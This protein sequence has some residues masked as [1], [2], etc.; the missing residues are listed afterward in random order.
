M[1]MCVQWRKWAGFRQAPSNR[2]KSAGPGVVKSTSSFARDGHVA[3]TKKTIRGSRFSCQWFKK[4]NVPGNSDVAAAHRAALRGLGNTP[5]L[6]LERDGCDCGRAGDEGSSQNRCKN[7][8]ICSRMF[9]YVRLSG[10]TRRKAILA[11]AIQK[12]GNASF[13][14]RTFTCACYTII[15]GDYTCRY[16]A[17][18]SLDLG[19]PWLAHCR[20]HQ[21]GE[22]HGVAAATPYRYWV[23]SPFTAFYRLLS[24]F[25]GAG[26]RKCG[27]G[28]DQRDG[29]DERVGGLSA[30]V[31]LC[32]PRGGSFFGGEQS[33]DG[34]RVCFGLGRVGSVCPVWVRFGSGLRN[35]DFGAKCAKKSVWTGLDRF[36]AGATQ[37]GLGGIEWVAKQ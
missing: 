17:L 14:V 21:C 3:Q 11:A 37:T 10:K 1:Y 13:G 15:Y 19:D 16:F 20:P 22:D 26:R 25:C 36:A 35:A 24:P 23:Q 6:P 18:P 2:S 7:V 5:T 9:R 32:R 29:N 34:S 27:V 8:R 28:K 30:F 31:G 12:P 33:G 4:S